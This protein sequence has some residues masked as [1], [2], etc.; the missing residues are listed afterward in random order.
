[1]RK[2]HSD[3]E[4]QLVLVVPSAVKTHCAPDCFDQ[5]LKGTIDLPELEAL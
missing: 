1:M 3:R 4:D 5:V 2:Q